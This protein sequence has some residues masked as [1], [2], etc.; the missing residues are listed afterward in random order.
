MCGEK[1]DNRKSNMEV[2]FQV[3]AVLLYLLGSG[4]CVSDDI[5]V[6]ISNNVARPSDCQ[7][8]L[9][10]IQVKKKIIQ[11]DYGTNS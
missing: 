8:A 3:F 7:Q 11:A 5:V 2:Q 10:N 4:N 6:K 1:R 9:D